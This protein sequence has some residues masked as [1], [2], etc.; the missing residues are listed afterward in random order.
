MASI[1]TFLIISTCFLYLVAAG[2]FSKAVWLFE[3]N[4]VSYISTSL[5]SALSPLLTHDSGLN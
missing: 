3:D 1:Q 5:L 2:L 4:K